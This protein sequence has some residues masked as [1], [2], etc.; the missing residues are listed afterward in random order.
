MCKK[1][2]SDPP[3][4]QVIVFLTLTATPPKLVPI[5]IARKVPV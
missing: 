3:T 5:K 1:G 2:F 4:F